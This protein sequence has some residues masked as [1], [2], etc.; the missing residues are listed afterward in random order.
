MFKLAQGMGNLGYQTAPLN[1]FHSEPFL[2]EV[3]LKGWQD[4]LH[5]K[6]RSRNMLQAKGRLYFMDIKR[7]K[8]EGIILINRRNIKYKSVN[9]GCNCQE[10]SF[11]NGFYM[12]W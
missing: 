10:K 1:H 2:L 11:K 7:N 5:E 12:N 8:E 3:H 6:F 4:Y 9:N